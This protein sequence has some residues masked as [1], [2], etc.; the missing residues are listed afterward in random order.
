MNEKKKTEEGE[1]ERRL[2]Y[3]AFTRARKK[4]FL[5]FAAVRT[6]F[7]SKKINIPLEFI[8]DIDENLIE[9]ISSGEKRMKT[10]YLE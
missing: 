9:D 8:S 1:E 6:I 3:V 2:F 7:G 10:V 5:S 4:V